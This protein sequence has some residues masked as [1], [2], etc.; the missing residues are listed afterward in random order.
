VPDPSIVRFRKVVAAAY[1][2]LESRRQEVNDLN[3]FPVADGDTGD[4]MTQTLQAVMVELDRLNGQLVDEIGRDEV[5]HAVARAA[6]LGARGNSGVIL[7]QVVRGAAEELSSRPGELIDP[8]LVSAALARAADAAYASVRN[9]AEGTMITVVREMAHRVSHELAHMSK[10]RLDA[11]AT[12]EEQD[13]LLAQVLERALEAAE[14]SVDRSPELLPVLREHGV[15]DAGGYGVTLLIAGLIAGLRGDGATLHEVPHQFPAQLHVAAQRHSGHDSSTTYRYCTNF[16]VMGEDLDRNAFVERLEGIGDSVLV[17]GDRRTLRVHVHTD[18]PEGASAL[19]AGA[20]TVERWDVADMYEQEDRRTARLAS[21]GDVEAARVRCGIVA[22]AA[23]AGM[24]K[25]YEEYGAFVVEGGQTLNPSTDEILAGISEVPADQVIVLPN[26]GNVI[27]AAERAAELS[28]KT[29]KVVETRS[30]QAGIA[31]LI[32][33]NPEQHLEQNAQRLNETLEETRTGWVAPA[34]RDDKKGR[35]R[36]GDAVGSVSV[37]GEVEAW[38]DTE[39]NIMAWGDPGSTLGAVLEQLA[40]GSELLTCFAGEGAPLD[41][42]AISVL[43][44]DGIAIECYDGGQPHYWW[45]IA[46]AE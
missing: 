26:S 33:H 44:P 46:A 45:L 41:A 21:G 7:S 3:V 19:F 18:D 16:V 28:E 31:C 2:E 4:N 8:V 15:V 39:S 22:V 12:D 23:G 11:D 30:L 37:E 38:G 27:M 14:A 20:G 42:E 35:Y 9:P 32:E 13:E 25:L 36:A 29:V 24:K 1:A 43:A 17:V 5:V 6:L 40:K 34:A 10:Q